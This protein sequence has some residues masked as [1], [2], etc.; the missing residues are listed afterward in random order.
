MLL[1]RTSPMNH[2]ESL[3]DK[4][5]T[6]KQIEERDTKAQMFAKE[7]SSQGAESELSFALKQKD[8]STSRLNDSFLAKAQQTMMFNRLGVNEEKIKEIET[9]MRELVD[10]L[11]SGAI[12]QKEFEKQMSMLQSMLAKEYRGGRDGEAE[13]QL[14]HP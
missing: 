12:E 9:Q 14:E 6:A 11:E 1:H 7:M 2:T 10:R 4:P 3:S 8:L 5:L 13:E